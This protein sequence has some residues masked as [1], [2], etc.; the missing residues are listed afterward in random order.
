MSGIETSPRLPLPGVVNAP[1]TQA[2][3]Y[4]REGAWRP[5]TIGNALR[6]VARERPQRTAYVFPVTRVGKLD[7]QQMRQAIAEKLAAEMQR[8]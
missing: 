5:T 4:L 3:R 7:R 8:S 6:Q 1:R 2:E